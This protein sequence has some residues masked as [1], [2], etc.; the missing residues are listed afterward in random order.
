MSLATLVV[1]SLAASTFA[2]EHK[3]VVGHQMLAMPR[4]GGST[5]VAQMREETR[6]WKD[7]GLDA[8]MLFDIGGLTGDG[9]KLASNGLKYHEAGVA[10]GFKFAISATYFPSSEASRYADYVKSLADPRYAAARLFIGGRQYLSAYHASVHL[11]TATDL[12]EAAGFPIYLEPMAFPRGFFGDYASQPWESGYITAATRETWNILYGHPAW[13]RAQGMAAFEIAASISGQ[14]DQVDWIHDAAR[15]KGKTARASIVAYYKGFAHKGNWMCYE[16]WGYERLR[17]SLKRAIDSDVP[18]IEFITLNDFGESSYFNSWAEGDPLVIVDHWNKHDVPA[19]IDHSG[20][21]YFS[22]RYIEWF[23]TGQEPAITKDELYYSYRLH[24]RDAPDYHTLPQETKTALAHWI[25]PG[26]PA[27][28]LYRKGGLPDSYAGWG[29]NYKSGIQWSRFSDGIHVAVRLKEPA[30]VYVNGIRIGHDLPAGEHLLVKPG[31][32]YDGESGL[33][34]P[35]HTFTSS[36]F[37]YPRFEIRRNGRTIL[38]HAGELEI[39]AHVAPGCWNVF[40]RRAPDGAFVVDGPSDPPP[41]S[42]SR[43]PYGGDRHP[44]PGRIETEHYDVGGQGVAYHD[45]DAANFGGALRSEGVDVEAGPNGHHVAFFSAGEWTTYSSRIDTAGA[46]EIRIRVACNGNGGTIRLELDGTDISGPIVVPNTGGWMNWRTLTFQA[47]LGAGERDLRLVGIANGS[48]SNFIGNVDWIEFVS[49]APPPP[50]EEPPPPPVPAIV[51]PAPGSW[52][53]QHESVEVVVGLEEPTTGDVTLELFADDVLVGTS[54]SAPAVFSWNAS[55]TGDHTF[56]ARAKRSEDTTGWATATVD[57]SVVP[58]EADDDLE[59]GASVDVRSYGAVPDDEEDD[60]LAIQAAIDA[61]AAR[62][63][64]VAFPAGTFLVSP[65]QSGG[66]ALRIDRD[67]TALVGA[68]SDRTI[69]S[70]RIFGGGDPRTSWEVVDGAVHRGNAIVV[71]GS[72]DAS[73]PRTAIWIRGLRLDG[74]APPDGDVRHPADLESGRGRDSSHVGLVLL[75]DSHIDGLLLEDVEIANF[76]G[77]SVRAS[78]PRFGSIE[79]VSCTFRGSN[80]VGLETGAALRLVDSDLHDH[81]LACATLALANVTT[82]PAQHAYVLDNVFQPTRIA[83]FDGLDGLVLLGDGA[84]SEIPGRRSAPLEIVVQGNRFLDAF[85]HGLL[86]DGRLSDA[87]VEQNTFIDN[88]RS[89][90]AGHGHITLAP[91][92]NESASAAAV[93]IRLHANAFA[94]DA[95]STVSHAVFLDAGSGPLDSIDISENT[96]ANLSSSAGYV[97]TFLA[98]ARG[99]AYDVSRTEFSGNVADFVPVAVEDRSTESRLATRPVYSD[100][101]VRGPNATAG[102]DHFTL[103][104]ASR[105]IHP[106]WTH[107]IVKTSAPGTILSLGGQ[108]AIYPE[109]FET[110]LAADRS[111]H[112]FVLDAGES[113]L[114][115]ARSI[116]VPSGS[117]VQLV[118]RSGRF[119]LVDRTLST[120]GGPLAVATGPT[121]APLAVTLTAPPDRLESPAGREITFTATVTGDAS[122]PVHVDFMIDGVRIQRVDTAPWTV[123]W[124]PTRHGTFVAQ[125]RVFGEDGTRATS[126]TLV[127]RVLPPSGA[128]IGVDTLAH[129]DLG[130]PG[131]VGST[132]YDAVGAGYAIRSSGTG[133]G[134]ST[135]QLRFAHRELAGD[136]E[137]TVRLRGFSGT[138]THGSA[139]LVFRGSL[140][141]SAPFIAVVLTPANG[142]RILRRATHGAELAIEASAPLSAPAW[143][144]LKR[145]GRR[146]TAFASLDGETWTR[147]GESSVELPYIAHVGLG[148]AGSSS[149]VYAIAHYDSFSAELVPEELHG[150]DIGAPAVAGETTG[151]EAHAAYVVMGAGSDVGGTRDRFHF[152]RR[153]AVGDFTMVARLESFDAAHPE[154]KAGVMIREDLSAGARNVLL[155]LTLEQGLVFQT[156]EHTGG[157]TTRTTISGVTWPV[158]LG[159]QRNGPTIDAFYSQDGRTWRHAGSVSTA[160]PDEVETGLAV[161]S[162]SQ[163]EIATARFVD[164]SVVD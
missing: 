68:G 136:G 96:L 48:G 26:Q 4:Y 141:P 65:Q 154:A 112:G 120:E 93:R 29:S 158:S 162:R 78:S 30:D 54:D 140:H 13:Q 45:L 28:W 160:L 111:G 94:A 37:G 145:E 49:L 89:G 95:A 83:A 32:R 130:D 115:L 127:F 122:R 116:V 143:L 147:V 19:I 99:A 43:S 138:D 79:I 18:A 161:T 85:H 55:A 60:T 25:A 121:R 108:A 131:V 163:P 82:G 6:Q 2:S 15:A 110:T 117:S 92:R 47:E 123:R 1:V 27:D 135:D 103:T 114:A 67:D 36:D 132:M 75:P 57:V 7:M 146:F 53:F 73:S 41:Q 107:A 33:G 150:V 63:G 90:L 34:Y 142:V 5:S 20:F 119:E 16:G 10:E 39:T 9:P 149:A 87:I 124:T 66:H 58:R 40:A 133:F 101:V 44:I 139:G 105:A 76:L 50:P 11:V 80:G 106:V 72:T 129:V 137:L 64:T 157:I 24:P 109:A 8:V 52:F 31:A 70:F 21:R 156:R 77:G 81:A 153:P 3:L 104:P 42:P 17:A 98:L 134:G 155:A 118:K 61:V 59:P 164:T 102:Q 84:V 38:D 74:N 151:D 126:S 14:A 148:T 56:V 22:K 91:G 12:L 88:G 62:G 159:L 46:Y 51:S 152:A 113:W 125:A 71:V 100:N 86:V 144:R 23:K 35:L 97:R 69:L 128:G